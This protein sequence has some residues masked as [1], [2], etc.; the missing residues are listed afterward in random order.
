M[1]PVDLAEYLAVQLPVQ[2]LNSFPRF[3]LLCVI[4]CYTHNQ[5]KQN[6]RLQRTRRDRSRRTALWHKKLVDF[7]T[8]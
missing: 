3:L 4:L 5:P 8:S 7:G 1:T 6:L 2:G